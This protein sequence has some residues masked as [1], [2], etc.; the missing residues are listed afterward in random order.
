MNEMIYP[1][2]TFGSNNWAQ[3]NERIVVYGIRILL[4]S[5]T[6]A[7]DV[8]C[9]EYISKHFCLPFFPRSKITSS[10]NFTDTCTIERMQA[11]TVKRWHFVSN[12]LVDIHLSLT[13]RL[14]FEV[15]LAWL[16]NCMLLFG[17]KASIWLTRTGPVAFCLAKNMNMT[18]INQY[19]GR[20]IL[21]LLKLPNSLSPEPTRR[22]Q[23]KKTLNTC[24]PPVAF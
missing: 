11:K 1:L 12:N 10:R 24:I 7:A 18:P 19:K 2:D 13:F 8:G 21:L 22:W 4:Q 3:W 5:M 15:F 6:N 17:M 16:G 20:Q 14:P 23:A 9:H